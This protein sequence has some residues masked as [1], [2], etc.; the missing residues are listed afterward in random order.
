MNPTHISPLKLIA[1]MIAATTFTAACSS[2][3]TRMSAAPE[4]VAMIQP[5]TDATPMESVDQNA[6]EDSVDNV[7]DP[8]LGDD[9]TA[10][11]TTSPDTLD[12][13]AT[14]EPEDVDAT[15]MTL[16]TP[17]ADSDVA[18]PARTTFHFGF[19]KAELD[20]ENRNI[21]EEHGKFLAQH[22]DQKVVINGHSDGQGDSKYNDALSLKRAN[23]VA[24]LLRQQGVS[25][26]QI[27]VFS[28]GATSPLADAHSNRDN[29]RVE[30]QYAE[31]YLVQSAHP[32]Q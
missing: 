21:V 22:P 9:T 5:V 6:Y 31:D 1:V 10:M 15:V 29:R 8:S 23:Y 12:G 28:W 24:D 32:A 18:R 11:D 4:P 14:A 16:Q 20:K 7:A 27:E 2:T 3:A 30:M 17:V 13:V 25:K 26:D 19:N